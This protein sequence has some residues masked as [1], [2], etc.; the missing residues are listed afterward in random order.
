MWHKHVHMHL[1]EEQAGIKFGLAGM[2]VDMFIL[3]TPQA[4]V[5]KEDLDKEAI[6]LEEIKTESADLNL[7]KAL[8]QS[9]YTG[10]DHTS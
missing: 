6:T 9:G 1:Q 7:M 4:A 2:L 10:C 3:D 8:C 5:V